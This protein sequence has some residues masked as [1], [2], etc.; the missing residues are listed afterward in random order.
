MSVVQGKCKNEAL[1]KVCSCIQL[2]GLKIT[3]NHWVLR[4]VLHLPS[5]RTRNVGARGHHQIS[6]SFR[7]IPRDLRLPRGLHGRNHG[8]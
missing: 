4:D 8:M 6:E 1:H 2:K 5:Y 3:G 7:T